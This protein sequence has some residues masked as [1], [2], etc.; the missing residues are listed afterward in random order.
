[1]Y[2]VGDQIAEMI[3]AHR[4][5]SKREAG[6]RAIELLQSVGIPNPE[7]RV[8]DY[9]H[10]FSGG[11][12]QRVMI[13]MAL[14]LDPD[15]TPRCLRR[16]RRSQNQAAGLRVETGRRLVEQ[17]QPRIVDQRSGD[18]QP[19]LHPARQRLDLVVGALGQLGELEQLVGAPAAS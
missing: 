11:M 16:Y 14:S 6:D 9:P 12:R 4:D 13:A 1:M 17:Q 19:R 10:E 15:V 2:R 3:R 18:G 7:R 8:R 5:V